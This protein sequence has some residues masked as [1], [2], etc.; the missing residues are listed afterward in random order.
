MS[1]KT[2]PRSLRDLCRVDNDKTL[3]IG[4]G[5]YQASSQT[6]R[7]LASFNPPRRSPSRDLV[8]SKPLIDARTSHIFRNDSYAESAR[9]IHRNNVVGHQY[10]LN[11]KPNGRILGWSDDKVAEFQKDV[12]SSFRVWAE[13]PDRWLDVT[14]KHTFSEMIGFGVDMYCI[15]GEIIAS[16]E[17]IKNKNRPYYTAIQMID[18][19]RLCNPGNKQYDLMKVHGGIEFDYYGAPMAYFVRDA[20]PG[21]SNDYRKI[22]SW[23]KIPAYELNGR[24]KMIHIFD[25]EFAGQ[26]RGVSKMSKMVK[27]FRSLDKFQDLA[28]EKIIIQ[29]SYAA[30]LE[31]PLP[32][33]AAAALLGQ[34]QISRDGNGYA[35]IAKDI[36]EG[37]THFADGDNLKIDGSS[38]AV[39]P[40]GS[41]LTINPLGEGSDFQEYE[42]RMIRYLALGFGVSYEEFAHDYTET[43]YSSARAAML[44]TWKEMRVVKAKIADPF[45]TKIYRLWLEEAYNLNKLKSLPFGSLPRRYRGEIFDALSRCQW[46]GP[47]KGQVDEKKETEAAAIRIAMGVSTLEIESA[48]HGNNWEE[49]LEQQA[50]E[51]KKRQ[52]LGLPMPDIS[53]IKSSDEDPPT[54]EEG[55]ESQKKPAAKP[56]KPPEDK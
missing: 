7:Q 31:T 37:T 18:P 20:A 14:R 6:S 10:I 40:P 43:N 49:I 4:G 41:K 48:Q 24:E 39:I 3:A 45:A 5:S 46:I 44:Q 11:A 21:D 55:D 35:S 36:L 28:F 12:E 26:I 32:Q 8:R 25:T 23:Q 34:G 33:D 1:V 19:N 27:Q 17:W 13:S 15:Y 51:M 38:V 54:D 22:N 42:K 2:K 47:A 30:T 52:E 29:S 50:R 56:A 53:G 9:S 16:C